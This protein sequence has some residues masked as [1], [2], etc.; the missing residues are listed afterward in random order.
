MHQKTST[1]ILDGLEDF[2][3]FDFYHCIMGVPSLRNSAVSETPI[4][5]QTA[6]AIRQCG[7]KP[8]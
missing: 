5:H 1:T 6:C 3:F 4:R 2:L 8:S 7:Q